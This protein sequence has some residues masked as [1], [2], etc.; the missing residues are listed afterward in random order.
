[1]RPDS[2]SLRSELLASRLR[3]GEEIPEKLRLIDLDEAQ[4]LAGGCLRPGEVSL[5][6]S[7][8]EKL[9]LWR[10]AGIRPLV[11]SCSVDAGTDAEVASTAALEIDALTG[12]TLDEI[13]ISVD[14][15]SPPI[16]ADPTAPS[17]ERPDEKIARDRIHGALLG[18]AAGDSL[19]AGVE[20]MPEEKIESLYGPFRDF[21]SGRGWGPGSPT[22]ETIFAALWFREL[23]HKRTVHTAEDRTRLAH[24]LARWVVGR[25]R[26]FGHMTSGILRSYLEG[27]PVPEALK[28][29][30]RA[31]REGE[32]N[33]ALSRAAA[34]GIAI[35]N[36]R[37]LR[38]ASAIAASAMTHPAPVC[39]A[40]AMAVATG[41][42]ATI[43]GD[44]PLDAAKGAVWDE[45][46]AEALDEIGR[47]WAPGGP[48]WSS[49]GRSHVLKSLRAGFWAVRQP[50]SLEDVLCSLIHRGGDTDTHGAIAG[51]L[52]GAR[53]GAGA[54]PER[55]LSQLKVKGL[56]DSLVDRYF[57]TDGPEQ[58]E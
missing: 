7:L 3:P 26:D 22:R 48:E 19:G 29:W 35:P 41:V 33:A 36:Q 44:D 9:G 2:I 8:I 4:L 17:I 34:V 6:P 42:A 25:P 24:A 37:D 46:A 5:L 20:N 21:V 15:S 45:Q 18:L 52:L 28:I 23:S 53:D 30:H 47:G 50:G 13:Q 12:G 54:I 1:M 38:W 51:A 14:R 31:N 49:H 43:R 40:S 39:L 56:I 27:P 57:H 58:A 10:I 32:F 11:G 55:W 16:P